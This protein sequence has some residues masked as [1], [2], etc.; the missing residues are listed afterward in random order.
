MRVLIFERNG[1]LIAMLPL[2]ASRSGA[3]A[4]RC[5]GI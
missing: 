4:R 2:R 5:Q 3:E 1:E